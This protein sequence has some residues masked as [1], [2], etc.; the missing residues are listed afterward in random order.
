MSDY[1][2]SS[3]LI[4]WQHPRIMRKARELAVA[5]AAEEA[6]VRRSFEF[7]RDAVREPGPAA[8]LAVRASD[9][10]AGGTGCSFA[11]AHLL[12]ALMRANR[13]PAGFC[14]QRLTCDDDPA[15][16]RLHGLAAVRLSRHGWY[17]LDLRPAV[18]GGQPG[19]CAPPVE[20]FA[21]QA[22]SP[23]ERDLPEIWPEPLP[24]VVDALRASDHAAD[25][26]RHAPDIELVAALR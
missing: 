18:A 25:F 2:T 16:F 4:D 17:R 11:K 1:L 13:I 14:Y 3:D 12:A 21:R 8:P 26:E 23:G 24:L 7:V 19:R 22:Q 5:C 6:L 9:V 10:L 15:R 20:Q